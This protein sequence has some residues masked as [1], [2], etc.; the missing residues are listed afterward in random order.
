MSKKS[1]NQEPY[2]PGPEEGLPHREA[3]LPKPETDLP[4]PEEVAPKERDPETDPLK[5]WEKEHN[6]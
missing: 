4:H 5:D 6:F 2:L 3:N 1:E